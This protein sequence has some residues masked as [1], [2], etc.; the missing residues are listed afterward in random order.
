MHNNAPNDYSCPICIAIAG[1]EN[2]D[3]WIVQEDIFYKDDLVTGFIGSK[4]IKGN[5]CHPLIVPN[6]HYENVY[7][8]PEEVGHRV[9]DISKRTA[10]G[11]KQ[12]RS[13]DGVNLIQNNEPAADQHAFHYHLHVIPRF[14][15]D[16]FH[17][18]FWKAER[19]EPKDRKEH[20]DAMRE[21]FKS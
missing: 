16:S 15:G 7:D 11:L 20:A 10:I 17:E 3:T 5:E 8:L 21:Y 1:T 14:D 18:E 13:C 9:F 4:S 12:V 2:D 19:S 6:E